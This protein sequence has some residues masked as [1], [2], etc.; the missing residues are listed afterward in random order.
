V[1]GEILQLMNGISRVEVG[2]S[3]FGGVSSTYF[4]L[5]LYGLG[6]DADFHWVPN[7]IY[8]IRGTG[9]RSWPFTSSDLEI[10]FFIYP[11]AIVGQE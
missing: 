9:V 5:I 7:F 4:C 11:N 1:I 10:N 3:V 6:Q 8:W 2:N